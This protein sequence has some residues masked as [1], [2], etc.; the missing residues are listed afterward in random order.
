VKFNNTPTLGRSLSTD[1]GNLPR[2]SHSVFQIV[3]EAQ[4]VNAPAAGDS[5]PIAP[6]HSEAQFK[7]LTVKAAT[8]TI[9]KRN[10]ILKLACRHETIVINGLFENLPESTRPRADFWKG[11]Q[12]SKNIISILVTDD[13]AGVPPKL[14]D[15]WGKDGYANVCLAAYLAE[16]AN[17]NRQL[18][19]SLRKIP[20]RFRALRIKPGLDLELIAGWNTD[21]HWIISDTASAGSFPTP[22]AATAWG[23][24]I[25]AAC[26]ASSVAF[27]H[28]HRDGENSLNTATDI[29]A[30]LPLHPFGNGIDLQSASLFNREPKVDCGSS[31]EMPTPVDISAAD[32]TAVVKLSAPTR[33]DVCDEVTDA[34]MSEEPATSP[35]APDKSVF[36]VIIPEIVTDFRIDEVGTNSQRTR[37]D[38]LDATVRSGLKAWVDAGIALQ[39]IRDDDLWRDGGY[40]SF[41][42]YCTIVLGFTTNYANRI[43]KHAVIAVALS[44]GKLPLD[45][46]GNPIL[47][48]NE[49]QVRPLAKLKDERQWLKAWK[50]SVKRA[51][52]VPTGAIVN[53]VACELKAENSPPKLPAPGP[54]DKL[55]ELIGRLRQAVEARSLD[56]VREIA[57]EFENLA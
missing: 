41:E 2:W 14:P 44:K 1:A 42:D 45:E 8:E 33:S 43:A 27:F 10:R 17:A 13:P 28:H 34:F 11:I 5:L 32:D 16:D 56:L 39:E 3:P 49:S 37:F 57:T 20:A 15:D 19:E 9:G 52:G 29:A 26:H 18:L 48:Q 51:S 47:P 38:D 23:G 53:A 21:I 30:G 55:R 12:E 22:E 31:S 35:S 7:K 54:K 46:A 25:R 36:A 24:Q 50:L 6:A 40:A 4:V